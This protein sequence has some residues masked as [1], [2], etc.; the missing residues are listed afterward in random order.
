[1]SN[2]TFPYEFNHKGRTIKVCEIRQSNR[3]TARRDP[4]IEPY[5]AI[6]DGIEAQATG[7]TTRQVEERAKHIVDS[8]LDKQC[9]VE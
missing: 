4:M 2:Q 7:R 6:I 8:S 1:M 9:K 3:F 5:Y